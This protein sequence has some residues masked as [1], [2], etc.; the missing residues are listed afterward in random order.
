M[1][2]IA[3][4]R[5]SLAWDSR[6]TEDGRKHSVKKFRLLKDGRTIVVTGYIRDITI[7]R[8]LLD[9]NGYPDLTQSIVENSSIIIFDKGKVYAYDDTKEVRRV[10]GSDAWGSGNAYAMGAL[11]HGASAE[12]ACRIACKYSSTCGGKIHIAR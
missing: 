7:A 12:E 6:A 5:T 4:D 11:A 2:V 8:D 1:T 9:G 3:W 10:K